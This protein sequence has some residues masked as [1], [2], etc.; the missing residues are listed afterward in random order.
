MRDR[1]FNDLTHRVA[2]SIR[3]SIA[4]LKVAPLPYWAVLSLSVNVVLLALLG[5][6]GW[7]VGHR[8]IRTPSQASAA[9]SW[10]T[11]PTSTPLPSSEM[12]TPDSIEEAKDLFAEDISPDQLGE[13]H[14]L[15]YSEWV[16]ILS[17]EA[18]AM[19]LEPPDTLSILMGDSISLWFPHEQLPQTTTWLNQGISGEV[20]EGLLQ[21]LDL[22][23]DTQPDYIFVMIGINDLLRDV[24][25]RQLLDN[26]QDIIRELAQ[27]HPSA[28]IVMQ[29]ILPHS[30][31]QATWE[32]KEQLLTI[33]NDRIRTLNRELATIANAEN[34]QF[35]DLVPLFS[36]RQGNLPM[37][38]STDGLHLNENGYQI[39]ANALYG[40][41][42]ALAANSTSSSLQE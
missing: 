14:Q 27:M 41:Q 31:D 2:R 12:P 28:T 11:T 29:S 8:M 35:L 15:T 1:P 4:S 6:A 18:Q 38:L 42:Q 23:A 24:S 10:L 22:I 37:A 33:S 9:S 5:I 17:K 20:S 3:F 13:R 39:W 34:V 36:D 40:Y 7:R 19:V 21:R 30:A 32:G 25:D 16:E 26:Q